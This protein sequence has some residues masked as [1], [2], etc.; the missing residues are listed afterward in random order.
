MGVYRSCRGFSGRL[1]ADR[2]ARSRRLTRMCLTSPVPARYAL[3]V[4][5]APNIGSVVTDEPQRRQLVL[6]STP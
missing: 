1:V 6:V 3:R 5:C 4:T 2:A